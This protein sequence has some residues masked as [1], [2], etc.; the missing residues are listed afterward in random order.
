MDCNHSFKRSPGGLMQI[1]NRLTHYV[2]C[3]R[4]GLITRE[5][6]LSKSFEQLNINY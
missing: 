4:C 5:D 1:R 6:K 3:E 2:R